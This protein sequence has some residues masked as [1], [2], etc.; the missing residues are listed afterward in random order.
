MTELDEQQLIAQAQHDPQAFGA[1]YDRYLDRIYGFVYSQ[2]HDEA[3]AAEITS[4]TFEHALRHLRRY[5]WRGHGFGAWLYRIAHNELLQHYRRERFFQ[6]LR[7]F[8]AADTDIERDVYVAEQYQVLH[9]ALAQ[10]SQRDREV[11]ILRFFEGFSTTAE[12][13]S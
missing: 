13:Q 10:L 11:V 7:Q 8:W 1:L 4:A 2:T 9:Q 6:P 3:L 12:I 5:Q